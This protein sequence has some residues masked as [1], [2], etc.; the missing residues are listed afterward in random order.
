MN[1]ILVYYTHQFADSQLLKRC[2][3]ALLFSHRP[4]RLSVLLITQIESLLIAS[5]EKALPSPCNFFHY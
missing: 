5:S 4:I 2:Q 3:F 1:E